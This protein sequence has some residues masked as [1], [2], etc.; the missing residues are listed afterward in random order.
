MDGRRVVYEVAFEQL[1]KKG[2]AIC[3][4]RYGRMHSPHRRS[5]TYF[6]RGRVECVC[7]G[8]HKS[9][10]GGRFKGLRRQFEILG[11]PQIVA[12][13]ETD[14]LPAGKRDAGVTRRGRPAVWLRHQAHARVYNPFN[15]LPRLIGRTIIDDDNLEIRLGLRQS[16]EDCRRYCPSRI[17][18]WHD[19]RKTRCIRYFWYLLRRLFSH[20][21]NRLRIP[22][23]TTG[24]SRYDGRCD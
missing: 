2:V 17:E 13:E 6:T 8:V 12:V 21:D 20:G 14:E 7:I 22:G 23:T 15:R 3:G 9:R 1:E 16:G 4:R 19:N 5:T 18:G 10:I 11:Q 24:S